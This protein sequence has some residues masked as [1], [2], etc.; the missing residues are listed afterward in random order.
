VKTLMQN[1]CQACRE[2]CG[3]HASAVRSARTAHLTGVP[4]REAESSVLDERSVGV[5]A[6][7]IGRCVLKHDGEEDE[8][9]AENAGY[10]PPGK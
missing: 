10:A 3:A 9:G 4:G 1:A 2:R 5:H 8:V 6:G 7:A